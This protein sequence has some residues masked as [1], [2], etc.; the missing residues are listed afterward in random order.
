NLR[1][2]TTAQ[3]VEPQTIEVE[4]QDAAGNVI[5]RPDGA[6][7]KEIRIVATQTI[8]MGPV[9]SQEA[10]KMVGTNGGGF[11]N[12]NS[13]HPFENPTPLSNFVQ[14]VSIFAI[15]SGLTY[16]YGRMA[17]DQRQGWA[18]WAAMLV[19]CIAGVAT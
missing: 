12:A 9:A 10:I 16:T 7:E 18:L 17:R 14:M 6:T 13:A 15:P 5:T 8:A 19:L 2:Y 11:F 1:P 3:L 4:K